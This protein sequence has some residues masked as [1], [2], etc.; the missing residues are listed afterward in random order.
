[1]PDRPKRAIRYD[2]NPQVYDWPSGERTFPPTR[3]SLVSRAI[4][5]P[6]ALNEWLGNCWYPLYVRAR[7]RGQSPEDAADG[8]QGFLEKLCGRNLLTQADASRGRLRSWLPTA[9]GNHLVDTRIK[10]GRL[11]RGGGVPHVSIDWN[12]V[13]T[14]CQGDLAASSDPGALYARAWALMLRPPAPSGFTQAQQPARLRM[15]V[16]RSA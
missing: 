15:A 12:Q 1:L 7:G 10:A 9:F 5:S 6:E 16:D 11:K 13:E 4:G 14:T 2:L 3:W 8:V